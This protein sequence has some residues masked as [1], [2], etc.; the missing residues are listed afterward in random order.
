MNIIITEHLT[1]LP[2]QSQRQ[3]G[4]TIK[5]GSLIRHW[6]REVKGEGRKRE[7]TGEP[8]LTGGRTE[9]DPRYSSS[10]SE[11]DQER[12]EKKESQQPI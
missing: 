12:K 8:T 11:S 6:K 7:K 10:T 1:G 3:W 2:G 9:E 4:R 5:G